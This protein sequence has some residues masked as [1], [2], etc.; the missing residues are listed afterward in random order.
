[1]FNKF[2]VSKIPVLGKPKRLILAYFAQISSIKK[3][4]SQNEEDNIAIEVLSQLGNGENIFY[5][6]I[7]A[8]HPS[9]LSNT[10]KMYRYGH[11]GITIEPNNEL[12][13]LHRITRPRDIQLNVGCGSENKI[14]SFFL[15]KTPVL[16]SFLKGEVDELWKTEYLPIF[17]LDSICENLN[18][19]KVDFLSIDVEGFDLEVL[20]GA[21][22]ILK[23]ICLVCVEANSDNIA[24][25]IHDFLLENNFR[26]HKK[27]K[28][29]YFYVNN[30]S[31]K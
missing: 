1:M 31:G 15:S 26:L 2:L 8:N 13:N 6:D 9:R 7:G 27:I 25:A 28:W 5:I 4:Y 23:N 11:Y 16:S 20:K 14:A 24:N 22:K 29:N 19:S 12:I 3:S 21:K 18:I 17:K 30:D 10:Y